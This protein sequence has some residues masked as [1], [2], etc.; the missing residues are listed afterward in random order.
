MAAPSTR[1]GATSPDHD[2]G[3]TS[4]KEVLSLA[5]RRRTRRRRRERRQRLLRSGRAFRVVGEGDRR[6][7]GDLDRRRRREDGL[8]VDDLR[9]GDLRD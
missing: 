6:S 3:S 4:A 9:R 2:A 1:H 8:G 7:W 5:E